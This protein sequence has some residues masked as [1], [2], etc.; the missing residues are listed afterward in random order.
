M[1]KCKNCNAQSLREM[2]VCKKCFQ[3]ITRNCPTVR[4]GV[5]GIDLKIR[6]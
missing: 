4:K 1:S 5:D 2:A 3:Y 6:T